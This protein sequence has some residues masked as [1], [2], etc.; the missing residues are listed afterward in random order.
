MTITAPGD[1]DNKGHWYGAEMGCLECG[2]VRCLQA[3]ASPKVM[4]VDLICGG[5]GEKFGEYT[6]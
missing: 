2:L 4:T 1:I 6:V 3:D 5:C